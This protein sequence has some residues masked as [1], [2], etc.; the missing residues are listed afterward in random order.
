[1]YILY[2]DLETNQ[3]IIIDYLNL[4]N[5]IELRNFLRNNFIVANIIDF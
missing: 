4:K 1:M 2:K 3:R 5:I